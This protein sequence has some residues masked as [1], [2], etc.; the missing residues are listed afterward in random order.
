[1]LFKKK[2]KKKIKIFFAHTITTAKEVVEFCCRQKLLQC[3]KIAFWLKNS[4]EKMDWKNMAIKFSGK[5]QCT[6]N[7]FF[8]S[9]KILA[10]SHD[11]QRTTFPVAEI[12]CRATTKKPP[13]L[14]YTFLKFSIKT[15]IE[16]QWK[17]FEC[18]KKLM[19]IFAVSIAST[20]NGFCRRSL[21]IT[22]VYYAL[23]PVLSKMKSRWNQ[24]LEG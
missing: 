18:M 15:N 10:K 5:N 22:S 11:A 17:S 4:P 2:Q 9:Q 8:L 6:A 19:H 16:A 1:M 24:G 14:F 21:K 3:Y 7:V 20:K 12:M 13:T 23:F